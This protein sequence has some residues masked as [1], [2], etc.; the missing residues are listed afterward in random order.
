MLNGLIFDFDGTLAE[1]FPVIFPAF[2]AALFHETGKVY[3]NEE[4]AALFGPCEE[5][6]FRKLLPDR[7]QEGLAIYHAEYRRLHPS[8]VKLYPGVPEL[9]EWL[10]NQGVRLAIVTGKGP[11]SLEISLQE[12]GLAGFF[13]RMESGSLIDGN[14]VPAIKRVVRA[15]GFDPGTVGYL[16]DAPSDVRCAREAGVIPLGACWAEPGAVKRVTPADRVPCFGSVSEFRQWFLEN[17]TLKSG[18][19]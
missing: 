6:I 13:D 7:W 1:T 2:R 4:I 19:R 15:W 5:G 9:L 10:K 8:L 14:K 16:G 18:L 17:G 3:R 11:T 12:L